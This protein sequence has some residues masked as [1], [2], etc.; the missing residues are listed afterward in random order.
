MSWTGLTLESVHTELLH[1]LNEEMDKKKIRGKVEPIYSDEMKQD[2]EV[3][4][5]LLRPCGHVI[6]F[7]AIQQF[8]QWR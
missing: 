3:M 8:N 2:V 7:W 1:A 4:P 6:L 5:D